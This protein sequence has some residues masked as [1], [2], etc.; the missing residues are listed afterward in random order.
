MV[1]KSVHRLTESSVKH[2]EMFH[3][4][5]DLKQLSG[6]QDVHFD[7]RFE[8]FVEFN[9]SCWIEDDG[10]FRVNLLQIGGRD[11]KSWWSD[12]SG[13]GRYLVQCFGM[14]LP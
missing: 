6:A 10:H 1:C 4:T 7:G 5:T 14:L 2:L 11:S 13:D 12:I 3:F 9:G 8:L